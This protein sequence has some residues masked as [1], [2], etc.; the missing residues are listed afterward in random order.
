[1]GWLGLAEADVALTDFALALECGIFAIWSL[2][3]AGGRGAA[4]APEGDTARAATTARGFALFF[5]ASGLAALCGGVVHGFSA[6]HQGAAGAWLWR[7]TL[8][9]IGVAAYA[10]WLLGAQLALAPAARRWVRRGA[11]LQL[12]VY[13]AVVIFGPTEF[14]VAIAVYLP[15]ALFLLCAFAYCYRRDR[16]R[17]AAV[18]AAAMAV[19]FAAA[20]IQRVQLGLPS[21]GLSHNALYH[22]VQALAFGLLLW[23]A[24]RIHVERGC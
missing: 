12:V 2:R 15:A 20:G 18:G 7:A 17:A 6:F 8:F 5:A 23:T 3:P 9:S 16:S 11:L 21:L 22:I 1:M 10:G 14:T 13:S 24:R 19:T 4:R